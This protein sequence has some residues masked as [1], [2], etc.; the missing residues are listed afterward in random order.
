MTGVERFVNISTDKAANPISVLGFSKRLS[1]ALTTA[2]AR[3]GEG[4]YL[5]VRFGNV[6]GSRGSVLTAFSA[7]IASGGPVDSHPSGCHAL[8]HDHS[9]GGAARHPSGC[10]RSRRRGA[11][12]RHGPLGQH[13]RGGASAGQSLR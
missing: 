12:T 10:H 6:L 3:M 13:R 4:T 9:R 1:E 5:S 11:R 8:L 7:Q 2:I